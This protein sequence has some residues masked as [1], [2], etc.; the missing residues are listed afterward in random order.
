MVQELA[1]FNEEPVVENKFE[2]L[3]MYLAGSHTTRRLVQK[4]DRL[5]SNTPEVPDSTKPE[6]K[7]RKPKT[8]PRKI[9]I[10][11]IPKQSVAHTIKVEAKQDD[12]N[13]EHVHVIETETPLR[14]SL[15]KQKPMS[16]NMTWQRRKAEGNKAWSA[17]KSRKGTKKLCE[18]TPYFQSL[19]FK[20]D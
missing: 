11:K 4:A 12:G 1:S 6:K 19:G 3:D 5:A 7:E 17:W 18:I 15:P 10:L 2:G 8:I 14:R 13:V 9:V 16:L 20:G